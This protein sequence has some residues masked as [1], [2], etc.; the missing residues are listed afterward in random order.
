MALTGRLRRMRRPVLLAL[1]VVALGVAAHA[2][3]W[4]DPGLLRRAAGGAGAGGAVLFAVAYAGLTLTPLPKNALSTTAGLLFGFSTGV[5]VVWSGAL[6]GALS[7]FG[8]ARRLGRGGAVAAGPAQERLDGLLGRRG[9]W[10]VVVVR[11]VPVLPFTVVN[12]ASGFTSLPLRHFAVG[13]AV[14]ILP[15]TAV[16]VALGAGSA[17]VP[18][19]LAAAALAALVVLLVLLARRRRRDRR[20]R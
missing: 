4:D 3:G 18:T 13:T 20:V 15:G 2:T 16:F 5:L 8:L 7:A 6:L 12:Y 17:H 10:G 14:G 11:L 1:A 19:S 9:L